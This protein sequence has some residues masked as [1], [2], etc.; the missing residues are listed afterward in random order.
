MNH[1]GDGTK[2]GDA[3]ATRAR[4]GGPRRVTEVRN[5]FPTR[6][7]DDQV[8]GGPLRTFNDFYIDIQPIISNKLRAWS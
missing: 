7:P 3:V 1:R 2:P 6:R 8:N 4:E 5:G